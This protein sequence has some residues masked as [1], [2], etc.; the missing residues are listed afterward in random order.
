MRRKQR[1]WK[2]STCF[3]IAA[4][5]LIVEVLTVAMVRDP[6]MEMIDK[7]NHGSGWSLGNGGLID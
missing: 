6:F 4:G 2:D 7:K 1:K 5:V 3:I